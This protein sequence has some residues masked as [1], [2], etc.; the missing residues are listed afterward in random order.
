MSEDEL[1]DKRLL[2][3]VDC[4]IGDSE[5]VSFLHYSTTGITPRPY[6]LREMVANKELM[7]F[8]FHNDFEMIGKIFCD[9]FYEKYKDDKTL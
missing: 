5:T 3:R 6:G 9:E 7:E 2:I 1:T 8:V 4:K